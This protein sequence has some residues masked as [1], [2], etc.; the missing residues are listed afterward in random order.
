MNSKTVQ[1]KKD[2][3]NATMNNFQKMLNGQSSIKSIDDS[4]RLT[5]V[6]FKTKRNQRT[7][8]FSYADVSNIRLATKHEKFCAKTE[9]KAK[10][11][12]IIKFR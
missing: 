8:F 7:N 10:T 5:F 3:K 2:T 6:D 1:V 11:T 12:C 4:K 9:P